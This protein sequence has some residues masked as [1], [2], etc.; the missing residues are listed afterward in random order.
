MAKSKKITVKRITDA[1]EYPY[2]ISL[3]NAF[4]EFLNTLSIEHH[5]LESQVLIRFS[6][7]T[8]LATCIKLLNK[9]EDAAAT[10]IIDGI[11]RSL[12]L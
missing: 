9:T 2:A 11:T 10:I 6:N 3:P 8:Q 12:N 5:V 4:G 1:V 7:K